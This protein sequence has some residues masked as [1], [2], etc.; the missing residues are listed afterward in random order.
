MQLPSFEVLGG[1]AIIV[2]AVA[3]ES[4]IRRPTMQLHRQSVSM[5]SAIE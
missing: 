2:G 1:M 4:G 5:L 3:E